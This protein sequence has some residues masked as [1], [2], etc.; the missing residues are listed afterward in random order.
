M[1][2]FAVEFW[3]ARRIVVEAS[4]EETALLETVRKHGWLGGSESTSHGER[5]QVWVKEQK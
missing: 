3:G 2:T 5:F 1:K 4:D